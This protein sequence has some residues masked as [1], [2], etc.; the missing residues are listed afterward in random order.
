MSEPINLDI[1]LFASV[2]EASGQTTAQLPFVAGETV[3]D[4]RRRI[5]EHLPFAAATI[6][7]SRLARNEQFASDDELVVETDIIAVIPPVAGG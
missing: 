5:A 1:L 2:A 3:A 4:L 6:N 7:G